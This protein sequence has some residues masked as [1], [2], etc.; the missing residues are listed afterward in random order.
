M[1]ARRASNVTAYP[2]QIIA[3]GASLIELVVQPSNAKMLSKR[4]HSPAGAALHKEVCSGYA[5][6]DKTAEI[7]FGPF[8]CRRHQLL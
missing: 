3:Q 8:S 6:S 2:S 7:L 5:I 1:M 4:I